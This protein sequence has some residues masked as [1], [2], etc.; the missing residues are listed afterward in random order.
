MRG[1][2]CLRVSCRAK[3]GIDCSVAAK[4]WVQPAEADACVGGAE[5]PVDLRRRV[6]A[7]LL[8]GPGLPD[9]FALLT[10]ARPHALS[11]RFPRRKRAPRPAPAEDSIHV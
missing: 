3:R 6:V 5:L 8:P 2:A 1:E 11:V 10:N 4:F 9:E 7:G